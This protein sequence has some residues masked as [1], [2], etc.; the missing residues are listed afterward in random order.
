MNTFGGWRS[1]ILIVEV[2][3]FEG[4]PWLQ[5]KIKKIKNRFKLQ[6]QLLSL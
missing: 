1:T 2:L 4:Y 3:E 5:P 6:K